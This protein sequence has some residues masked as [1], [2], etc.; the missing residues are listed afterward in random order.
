MHRNVTIVTD[1]PQD[2]DY[3][4]FTNITWRRKKG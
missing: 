1:S 2:F 4:L 3:Y